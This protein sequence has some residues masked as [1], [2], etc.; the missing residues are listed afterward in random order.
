MWRIGRSRLGDALERAYNTA[1]GGKRD[2]AREVA[3]RLGR[4]APADLLLD[5]GV[6]GPR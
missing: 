5:L 1:T 4:F 3:T 2:V 6:A